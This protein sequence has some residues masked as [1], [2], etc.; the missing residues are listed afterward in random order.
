[1]PLDILKGF[2]KLP[3]VSYGAYLYGWPVQKLLLS[4]VAFTS[5]WI[6]FFS[7]ATLSL[8]LGAAGWYVV[9]KPFMKF[10]APQIGRRT[11]VFKRGTKS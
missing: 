9:E 7:A 4:Y 1:M 6:L 2:N 10:R 11:F 5:P 3:D 8:L